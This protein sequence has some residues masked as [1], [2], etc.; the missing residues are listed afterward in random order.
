MSTNISTKTI[1]Q[2]D[3]TTVL[4]NDII[5]FTGSGVTVT[6]TGGA[7]QVYIPAPPTG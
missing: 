3:G 5:N 4:S 7:A 1:V 2:D 6:N